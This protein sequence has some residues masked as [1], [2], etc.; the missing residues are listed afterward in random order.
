MKTVTESFGELTFAKANLG[1]RRRTRRLVRAADL[2]VR[3]P[4][5][6]LPQK[7]QSPKDLRAFYRLVNREEVTHESILA[8]HREA[9]E[10]RIAETE[11]PVL[12]IHDATELD[13]TSLLSLE[14]D[15]GQIGNGNRRGY[16]AQNSLAVAAK[17]RQVLGL[18]NQVLHHRATVPKNESIA[19]KRKR[20]SRESLLWLRGVSPL[21]R[22]KKLIDICDQG[23]DTFEFIEH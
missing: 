10:E 11:G 18:C 20:E 12:V 4:G 15:L 6:T 13:Y 22:S 21:Q 8:P 17:T 7:L 9:V 23:A 1:D 3:R 14:D 19:A 16:I 5:G 2:M